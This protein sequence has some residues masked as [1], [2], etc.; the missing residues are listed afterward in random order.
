MTPVRFGSDQT[1]LP[2]NRSLFSDGDTPL[3]L[4]SSIC[5]FRG[6]VRPTHPLAC[7]RITVGRC[8]SVPS[9][10]RTVW[11]PLDSLLQLLVL[12]KG[13]AGAQRGVG[14]AQR[15]ARCSCVRAC[16]RLAFVCVRVYLPIDGTLMVRSTCSVQIKA[17]MGWTTGAC[18]AGAEGCP[19]HAGGGGGCTCTHVVM[20]TGYI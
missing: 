11:T 13:P 5:W 1:H 18:R 7:S 3:S 16:T 8:G 12:L 10:D 4:Q 17:W 2:D 20:D 15:R 14:T 19:A 6:P 9:T